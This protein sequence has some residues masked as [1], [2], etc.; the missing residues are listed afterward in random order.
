MSTLPAAQ[1]RVQTGSLAAVTSTGSDIPP[2]RQFTAAGVV[3]SIGR[4]PQA[5]RSERATAFAASALGPMRP[6]LFG[7]TKPLAVL[8]NG[9]KQLDPMW[10]RFTGLLLRELPCTV[11]LCRTA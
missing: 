11:L 8:M 3:H 4:P 5:E 9:V 6:S 2:L 10:S 1:S 7:C